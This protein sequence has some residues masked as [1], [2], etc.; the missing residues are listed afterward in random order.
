MRKLGICGIVAATVALVAGC[1][2]GEN[3]ADNAAAPSSVAPS[4]AAGECR[5]MV[6]FSE[7]GRAAAGQAAAAQQVAESVSLPTG[8]SI[9]TGRLSTDSDHPDEFAVAIDLCGGDIGTADELKPLA[10]KFAKAYKAA[11]VGARIFAL[12][13]A[14]YASYTTTGTTG[15]VKINDPDFQL[16]LWNGKPSEQA[17][18]DNWEVVGQ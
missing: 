12:Y 14:H 1:G 13:V 10:T 8:V 4:T 11:P 2:S 7:G 5:P 18:L 9:V 16:H 3:S 15:G 17:E 6:P